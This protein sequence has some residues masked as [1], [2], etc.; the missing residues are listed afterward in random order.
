MSSPRIVAALA[1]PLIA[2]SLSACGN[3]S[4]HDNAHDGH[5]GHHHVASASD[6][7]V[8]GGQ[9]AGFDAD[10]V[11]FAGN[12]IEHHQQALD[13][14][15]LVSDRSANPELI[16][17]AQQVKVAQE[18]EIASLKAFL[19]QWKENPADS[20]DHGGHGAMNMS[21]MVDEA[22]MTQ[23]SS[24]QG[25]EFDTLWLRSMIAHH[26]GAIE[27]ANAELTN[28]QN[29]D[30]KHLAQNIITVQQAEIDQMQKV[31]GDNP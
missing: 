22:T 17:L 28:G 6:T 16:Q 30:A 2:A 15:A 9:P 1:G 20:T 12:M 18:P 29:A 26:Q 4:S 10:D 24:L 11:A 21:G 13:L 14:A 31:L 7:P 27:M 19:V 3:T 25:A 5:T 23:L 8:I